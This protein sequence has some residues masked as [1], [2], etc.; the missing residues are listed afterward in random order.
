M[1]NTSLT[2]AKDNEPQLGDFC[3][4]GHA[5][6][7]YVYGRRSINSNDIVLG[8]VHKHAADQKKKYQLWTGETWVPLPVCR[9]L[10]IKVGRAIFTGAK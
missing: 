9:E 5:D 1:I 10:A 7:I 3:A 6:C 8:R 4:V 2:R